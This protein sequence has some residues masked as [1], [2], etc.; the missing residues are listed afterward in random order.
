MFIATLIAAGRLDDRLVDRALG[1]LREIDPKARFAGWIDEGDAVDLHVSGDRQAI[2][3]ALDDLPNVDVVVQP[4]E[5]RFR[6]LLVADMD[7]TIIG[8][9]CIDELADFAGLK[10]E[11]A[12]ITERAMQGKLDFK[13]ALR[14]R[15][16]LLSGL[17]EDA[18][19]RCLAER[20]V[21]NPGAATL[22]RTMRVGGARTLLVSGGFLS[23]AEPVGRLIGFDHVRA[24][25]LLFDGTQL[26]GQVEGPIV[27]A[28]AKL[29][30]LVETRDGLGMGPEQVLAIGDG[31]N[32]KLMVEEAGLGVAYRA[33]PALAE[34]ANARI[35]HHG[36]DALLWAQGIRRKEW[37][38]G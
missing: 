29:D 23:F 9:E 25:R 14:E 5:P 7:S 16:A 32:D 6:K 35:D 17:E 4:P 1:L 18:I 33:K 13:A 37:V 22:V 15:V 30:A 10:R 27:D 31:A 36:L 34:V 3:W 21:P 26:S 19:A 20:V 28:Q 12:E 2:R 24:N 11:V 38:T 8:Q